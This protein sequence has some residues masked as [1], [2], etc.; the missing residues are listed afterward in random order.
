MHNEL[1]VFIMGVSRIV[2]Y[3]IR[4]VAQFAGILIDKMKRLELD[5]AEIKMGVD[6]FISPQVSF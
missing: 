1:L 4:L 5:A 3:P 6:C 2:L